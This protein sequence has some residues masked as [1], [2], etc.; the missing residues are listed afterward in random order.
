MNHFFLDNSFFFL[1][2]GIKKSWK[3]CL[4]TVTRWKWGGYRK[5][6]KYQRIMS[7]KR[8]NIEIIK[9]EFVEFRMAYLI[10]LWCSLRKIPSTRRLWTWNIFFIHSFLFYQAYFLFSKSHRKKI[11]EQNYLRYYFLSVMCSVNIRFRKMSF[12]SD[13]D[14]NKRSVCSV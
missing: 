12:V 3:F 7:L 9:K 8:L 10:V 4:C 2:W 1:G 5:K 14:N 6:S 11:S 13:D